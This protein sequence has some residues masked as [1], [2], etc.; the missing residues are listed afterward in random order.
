MELQAESAGPLTLSQGEIRR[1][2][3]GCSPTDLTREREPIHLTFILHEQVLRLRPL[4]PGGFRS[5]LQ[6]VEGT[7]SCRDL[8]RHVYKL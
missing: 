2:K 3:M 6:F 4:R 8:D 7:L 5:L 1:S